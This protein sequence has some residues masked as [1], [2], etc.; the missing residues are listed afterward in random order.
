MST[1]PTAA[2]PVI[3][4][5]FGMHNGDMGF[6]WFVVMVLFWGLVVFGVVWLV[7]SAATPHPTAPSETPL[8]PLDR[9]LASGEISVEEYQARRDALS[10][11]QAESPPS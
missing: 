4:D 3:A 10:S 6:G 9:R 8:D 7:R 2:V 11:K 1:L 5:A